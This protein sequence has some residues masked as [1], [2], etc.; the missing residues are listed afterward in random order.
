MELPAIGPVMV[1]AEFDRCGY[2]AQAEP[3]G[4][5]AG[6]RVQRVA[7]QPGVSPEPGR[8]GHPDD[9]V[10]AASVRGLPRLEHYR[11][12]QAAL[13]AAAERRANPSLGLRGKRGRS[14]RG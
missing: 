13:A 4:I 5:E 8:V 9:Q 2:P 6:V 14:G 10:T 12:H 1:V 3:G 11:P 7:F